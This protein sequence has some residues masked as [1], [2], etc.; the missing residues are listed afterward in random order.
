MLGFSF[1][2]DILVATPDVLERHKDNIGLVYHTILAE[3][4]EIYAA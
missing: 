3:G 1:P 4:R 2:V